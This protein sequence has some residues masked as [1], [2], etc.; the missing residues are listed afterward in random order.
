METSQGMKIKGLLT[1]LGI[2]VLEIIVAFIV[3]SMPYEDIFDLA[4]R[5]LALYGYLILS[6]ATIMTPF[7][8]EITIA[9]GKHFSESIT[10]LQL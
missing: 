9:F 8:K 6:V 2:V 3:F 1:I 10:F 4:Q 5:F 7:I